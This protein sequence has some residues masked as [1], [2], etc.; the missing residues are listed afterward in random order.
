MIFT[1]VFNIRSLLDKFGYIN[2]AYRYLCINYNV[3]I[4]HQQGI[5]FYIKY[6]FLAGLQNCNQILIFYINF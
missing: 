4:K 5:C 3:C 2:M 6:P 1:E